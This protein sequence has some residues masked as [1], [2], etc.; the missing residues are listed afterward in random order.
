ML[1]RRRKDIFYLFIYLFYF[2]FFG[3]IYFKKL[4]K[5]ISLFFPITVST[6]ISEFVVLTLCNPMD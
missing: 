3:R 5:I 4:F 6:Y 1:E 2:L